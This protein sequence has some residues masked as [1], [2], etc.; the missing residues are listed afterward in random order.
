METSLIWG[1]TTDQYLKLVKHFSR[2]NHL[3]QD[4]L[5]SVNIASKANFNNA[6]IIHTSASD[7]MASGYK[8]FK[9]KRWCN[10]GMAITIPNREA[11]YA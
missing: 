6:W 3:T 11:T 4:N 7:H 2:R 8:L 9:T 5:P 10:H 1:V